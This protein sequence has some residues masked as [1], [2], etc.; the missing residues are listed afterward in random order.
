MSNPNGD[1]VESQPALAGP[2]SR[3]PLNAIRERWER[4]RK[5]SAYDSLCGDEYPHQEIEIGAITWGRAGDDEKAFPSRA[6]PKCDRH[7]HQPG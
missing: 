3:S 4:K 7:Q 1:L 5:R 6:A 2:I